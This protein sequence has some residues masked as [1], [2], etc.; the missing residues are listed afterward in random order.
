MARQ[1]FFGYCSCPSPMTRPISPVAAALCC[2]VAAFHFTGCEKPQIRVYTVAKEAPQATP[3]PAAETAGT[4]RA[5]RPRP[6]LSYTLPAGWQ[7][8]GGNSLSLV[9]FLV[10]T[11]AGDATVNITPLAGM[12]GREAAIV[13]MWRAQVG[14]SALNDQ[15]VMAGFSPVEVAGGSGQLFEVTG[16]N[17]GDSL[18]IVTA[19]AHRGNES[20]FYKLQ[21]S[22]AAVAA[23]KPAFLEFLKTVKIKEGVAAAT[24]ESPAP[25]AAPTPAMVAPESWQA[26]PPG[27][28][29]FAKFA[30]ATKDGA[31]AEVSVS[32]FPSDTGGTLANVNRWR[33]QLGLADVDEAGLQDCVT[34]LE[35]ASIAGAPGAM[36]ADLTNQ[37]RRMLGA[38]V[39]REGRWWFYKMMG[40]AAAVN[41][42]RENFVHFVKTQP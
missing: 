13:N 20:W 16:A 28:M 3:A 22:E 15:D 30:V 2:V 4:D 9:N 36:L 38:V 39:P 24:A 21:G 23:Q 12:Q 37:N 1:P 29:Q 32:V 14:Q 35:G 11:D 5:A 27:Q 33:R 26:L 8:M 40:D 10:K 19:F 18:R 31:K 25:E 17:A 41:A 42:E 7:E 6:Q 34:P